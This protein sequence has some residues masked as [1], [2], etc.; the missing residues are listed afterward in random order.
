MT[1]KESIEI[2]KIEKQCVL[3]SIEGCDRKCADCD[4][5]RPDQEIIAGYDTAIK[6]LE[7]IQKYREIGT[8]E[9]CREA[10][11]KQKAKKYERGLDRDVRCPVCG[12]YTTDIYE[13]RY[14]SYCGQ[15][16]E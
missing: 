16:L 5:V 13:H 14:C 9:E 6:A 8:V 2:I 1:E 11:E 12:T 10:V 3:K 7:E 15:R 4:S